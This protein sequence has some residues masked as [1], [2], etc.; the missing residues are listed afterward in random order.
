MPAFRCVLALVFV[1][2]LG[3][4][5]QAQVVHRSNVPA[6]DASPTGGSFSVHFP[7]AFSDVEMKAEDSG[8]PTAIVYM[9]TGLANGG[10][11]FTATET[12]FGGFTPKPM[13]E[14]MEGTKKRPGAVVSDVQRD[15]SG[16]M[17]RLSFTLTGPEGGYYFRMI[18]SGDTQYML[19]VQF[20]ESQRDAATGMKDDFFGS[21]KIVGGKA[22][23]PAGK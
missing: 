12:P 14:F 2:A 9:L 21:F 3:G 11:R 6:G 15:S 10:T 1:F 5:A 20:P 22:S 17:D 8:Y 19:V 7:I 4:F 18:R 23:A 16:G 13:E